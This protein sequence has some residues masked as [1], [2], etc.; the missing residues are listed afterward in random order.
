MKL[1]DTYK[2]TVERFKDDYDTIDYT[3]SDLMYF[4]KPPYK[5]GENETEV[6][7]F[8]NQSIPTESISE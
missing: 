4:A 6:S 3:E 1:P 5:V 2:E 8:K 7:S